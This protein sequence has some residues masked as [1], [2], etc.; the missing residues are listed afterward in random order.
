MPV[1]ELIERKAEDAEET[2]N[3][4]KNVAKI[5]EEKREVLE[6]ILKEFKED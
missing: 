2:K 1:E 4:T 6:P 3:E 5:E